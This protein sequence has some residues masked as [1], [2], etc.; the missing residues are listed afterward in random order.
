M[1]VLDNNVDADDI[2]D[3]N[4]NET[5]IH[6]HRAP[7]SHIKEFNDGHLFLNNTDVIEYSENYI[8][9]KYA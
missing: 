2:V 4:Q 9:K 6:K 7:C 1:K 5:E 8:D 3:V